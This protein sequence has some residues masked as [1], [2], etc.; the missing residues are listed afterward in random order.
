MALLYSGINIFCILILLLVLVE[1][2]TDSITQKSRWLF[3]WVL[4][5][6]IVFVTA[7]MCWGL[8]MA[9][10]WNASLWQCY[11][12]NTV[13]H[14]FIGAMAFSWFAYSEHLQGSAFSTNKTVRYLSIIP[15]AVLIALAVLTPKYHLL[16]YIDG[17]FEYHRGSHYFLQ[18]L[19]AAIYPISTSINAIRKAVDINYYAERKQYI[20]LALF[21]VFPILF[22]ILQIFVGDIPIIGMGITL[23]ALQVYINSVKLMISIDPLT[24][25]NSRS[26][27][28]KYLSRKFKSTGEK[29]SFY[30]I[31]M[32]IDNFKKIN[33]RHG[34]VEGDN[35]LIYVAATLRKVCGDKDCFVSR[36]G[37]D[38]FIIVIE[39]KSEDEVKSLCDKIHAALLG[40]RMNVPY[41]IELSMG[42]AQYS[43]RV[44]SIPELIILADKEL[45]NMKH[46][47]KLKHVRKKTI[48][49]KSF[50]L[51]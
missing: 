31:I 46:A 12:V 28:V 41:E 4:A 20:I 29:K 34:H 24:Q 22:G 30:L 42:F 47:K 39:A 3:V 18:P 36:Y 25:L 45:Y 7:D 32:D 38:E 27:L 44:K 1:H 2:I 33:D 16:F 51:E 10:F 49:I 48:G 9:G 35:A 50:R 43:D 6:A 37:G 26:Q 15:F 19:L 17:N 14:V 21:I 8:I 23:G 11:T 5:C 13:Y 40:N